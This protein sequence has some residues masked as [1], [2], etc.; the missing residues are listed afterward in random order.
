V[1]GEALRRAFPDGRIAAD[2]RFA[3]LD[4][5]HQRLLRTLAASP[6]TWGFSRFTIF[7]NFSL[8]VGAYGL[9]SS[10]EAMASFVA[11]L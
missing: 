9:P 6:D 4:Q 3:D 10:A 11:E 1:V 7:A 5:R 8:M 2:V